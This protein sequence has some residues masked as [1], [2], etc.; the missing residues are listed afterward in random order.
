[1]S[2]AGPTPN[3]TLANLPSIQNIL[4]PLADTEVIIALPNSTRIFQ[5]KARAANTTIKFAFI[6]DQ[7]DSTFIT[8]LPGCV[9]EENNLDLSGVNIYLQTDKPGQMIEV[10]SWSNS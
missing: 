8:L 2:G 9:Y 7:S 1:M 10:L 5:F 3:V 6:A 4:I